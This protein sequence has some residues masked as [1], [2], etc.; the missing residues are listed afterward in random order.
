MGNPDR[1]RV[2][3]PLAAFNGGFAVE[4]VRLGYRR[5]AAANQ[6]QLMAHLSR[7]MA[8]RGL[9]ADELTESVLAD[10]LVARRAEGYR[11]W[12]SPKAL[13]PLLEY[14]R[15]L[16]VAPAESAPEPGGAVETLLARYRCY[17]VGERGLSAATAALYAHL[18]RPLLAGQML[19]GQLDLASLT[20]ADVIGFVRVSCPGRAV[21]TAKLIVTAVR[22][23]LGFLHVE[24]VIGSPL[25]SAVPSVSGRTSLGVPGGLA[26]DAVARLL[27]CCDRNT[28]MGRRDYAMV[29]L[30]ARLGLRPGE[31][32]SL[33]LDDIDWRAGELVVTGKG[34]RIERL[35]LP[36]DVGE[37][38][39][40]YLRDGRP[41]PA[42]C[43]SVFV[44]FRAPHRSLSVSGVTDTVCRAAQ[45]AGLGCIRAR[46]LRHTAATAMVQAGAALPEVGQVLRH[47]RLLTT[48]IYAKVD[49]EG[50]RELSRPWPGGAV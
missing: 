32:R 34:H 25:A 47:R 33:Q 46:Q 41:A 23:L 44:R 13:W 4:L 11:L 17:L 6:L 40:E 38:V 45:R 9:V 24:G 15:G 29:V 26:P 27:A 10:F 31:V 36:V 2:I 14:L 43:R 3:G 35:P 49:I 22:S 48:S 7:W 39:A 16:G 28:P 1:V 30:L 50:L 37:A 5:N 42:D 19:D 8:Q 12:L 21:G 20:P 18:T